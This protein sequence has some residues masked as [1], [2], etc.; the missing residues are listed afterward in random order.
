[1]DDRRGPWYLLTGLILGAAL[2]LLYAWVVK[3]VEYFDTAPLSLRTEFKDSYRRV[4]AAAYASS[5]DLGRARAR[6]ALLNDAAP[7]QVLAAQAQRIQAEGGPPLEARNLALLASALVEQ[8]ANTQKATASLPPTESP[9]PVNS[10]PVLPTTTPPPTLAA[11]VTLSPTAGLTQVLPSATPTLLTATATP[12]PIMGTRTPSTP[13]TRVSPQPTQPSL[14]PSLT[15]GLPFVLKERS[16]VCD[17]VH[18]QALLQVQLNDAAGQPIP[19]MEIRITWPNGEDR[20]FT[21]FKP[22]IN[23]GYADFLMSPGV[24]YTLQVVDGSQPVGNLA[25][26]DCTTPDGQ[27]YRGGVVF[28]DAAAVIAYKKTQARDM[29]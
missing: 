28:A 18:S 4:I 14:T 19:G 1:M 7:E 16:K 23:L 10:P 3:P 12:T 25:V 15:P 9:S 8:P 11:T 27:T 6:L 17:A 22:D 24:T 5:R 13:T 2:G 20:F 29:A 21:G 26:V